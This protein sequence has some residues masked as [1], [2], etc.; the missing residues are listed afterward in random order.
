MRSARLRALAA[1]L[2]VLGV[3][4]CTSDTPQT[5]PSSSASA[6][7]MPT[8]SSPSS[9]VAQ[10][11]CGSTDVPEIVGSAAGLGDLK[12]PQLVVE[13]EPGRTGPRV[14]SLEVASD[15]RA[16]FTVGVR[17]L[18]ASRLQ[19]SIRDDT[20]VHVMVEVVRVSRSC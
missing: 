11:R 13:G 9:V 7:S 20:V 10:L 1:S 16:R 14:Q 3:A 4:G 5:S 15:G 17:T 6:T 19:V 2:V 8:R 18:D 12:T